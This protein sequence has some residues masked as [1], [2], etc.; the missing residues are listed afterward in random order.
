MPDCSDMIIAR[1]EA[2]NVQIS[3][4]VSMTITPDPPGS[5]CE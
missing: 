4:R 1:R 2:M 3:F 5:P